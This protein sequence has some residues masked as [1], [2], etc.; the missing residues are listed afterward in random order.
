[1]PRSRAARQRR[2]AAR[3]FRARRWPDWPLRWVGPAD[4]TA[5]VRDVARVPAGHYA[6]RVR[7]NDSVPPRSTLAR[8]ADAD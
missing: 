2:A 8:P 1:M 6:A 3:A 5:V 4:V 7:V